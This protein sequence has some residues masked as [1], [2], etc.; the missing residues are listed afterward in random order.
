MP[1]KDA[2][3]F[4]YTDESE[5]EPI[6]TCRRV[7]DEE[8]EKIPVLK[9]AILHLQSKLSL[10][11]A[12]IDYTIQMKMSTIYIV[13]TPE[14]RSIVNDLRDKGIWNGDISCLF[15]CEPED[16]QRVNRHA[17]N[18]GS[19]APTPDKLESVR[20]MPPTGEWAVWAHNKQV[21]FCYFYGDV[22]RYVYDKWGKST[23]EYA[24]AEALFALIASGIAA[25]PRFRELVQSMPDIPYQQG[26]L[27]TCIVSVPRKEFREACY[28]KVSALLL[29]AWLKHIQR[30]APDQEK[31]L[32]EEVNKQLKIIQKKVIRPDVHSKATRQN[33]IFALY[34]RET[35]TRQRSPLELLPW[36]PLA[37]YQEDAF[38]G[39]Q[40]KNYLELQEVLLQHSRPIFQHVIQVEQGDR[41]EWVQS[42]H[43]RHQ[44][45]LEA[46]K[47][48]HEMEKGWLST[49]EKIWNQLQEAACSDV[50]IAIND[51][52][53]TN[54]LLWTIDFCD[55]FQSKL[56]D[57]FDQIDHEFQTGASREG[58]TQE[59]NPNAV[60]GRSQPKKKGKEELHIEINEQI[61]M[62]P[63]P[64]TFAFMT[65][66]AAL[67]LALPTWLFV[68]EF[69]EKL[70]LLLPLAFVLCPILVAIGCRIYYK[71]AYITPLRD[72]QEQMLTIY[73]HELVAGCEE[74]ERAQCIA[75]VEKVQSELY[76][77]ANIM[78]FFKSV[79]PDLKEDL[80]RKAKH[81]INE[82]F[83]SARGKRD[84][85]LGNG[86]Y[87]QNE[88]ILYGI[89]GLGSASSGKIKKPVER[90]Y[91]SVVDEGN[92]NVVESGS[93][94][95]NAE[96]YLKEAFRD[97]TS[98]PEQMR[99]QIRQFLAD[100]L[101]KRPME[102]ETD[103]SSS[104]FRFE[105]NNQV[106]WE[107]ILQRL[108]LPHLCRLQEKAGNAQ[109]VFLCTSSYYS[110]DA[111]YNLNLKS[112]NFEEIQM[113]DSLNVEEKPISNTSPWILL[114]GFYT[115]QSLLPTDQKPVVESD[116][117]KR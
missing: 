85:F 34:L 50:E 2:I 27:S 31:S 97:E 89:L 117:E 91:E 110:S 9:D 19:D 7:K 42:V 39:E 106:L 16:Q 86:I 57:L 28:A 64:L 45:A 76:S 13:G 71:K 53:S 12:S 112:V 95:P 22:P 66:V 79:V 56:E 59:V 68:S 37:A 46:S 75:L 33:R 35:N 73:K 18:V 48:A 40:R 115:Y 87:L 58:E 65:V 109:K 80:E 113:H 99:E 116:R 83:S 8:A 70:V 54:G 105:I 104:D 102:E 61:Y 1:L 69:T 93:L 92:Q 62:T 38:Q 6:Y 63:S 81:T 30:R 103:L 47:K 21:T 94:F 17:S 20:V 23:F 4:I 90:I 29:D 111:S 108:A 114:A 78:S 82:L 32:E 84:C 74:T 52:L 96:K 3:G 49:V 100:C 41:D 10:E 14:T 44:E 60:Y 25:H 11:A 107:V 77:R 15:L 43:K 98:S 72:N 101:D 24:A 55:Q 67:A 88:D 36:T 26:T 5:G 51:Q